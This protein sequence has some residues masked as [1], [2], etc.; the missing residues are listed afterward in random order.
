M[1]SRPT[2]IPSVIQES[3]YSLEDVEGLCS[4]GEWESYSRNPCF[5][6]P[7]E[8]TAESPS[9]FVPEK[10]RWYAVVSTNYPY[11]K[12]QFYPAKH[13]G[14]TAT[15]PHQDLNAE[16]EKHLPWRDGDICVYMPDAALGRK[17]NN[18]DPIGQSKRLAWYAKRAV[19]WVQDASTDKL[20]NTGDHFELPQFNPGNQFQLAYIDS[21]ETHEFWQ[22]SAILY[23]L[24]E[25]CYRGPN[26]IFY[27][28]KFS[29]GEG[30]DLLTLPWGEFKS[31]FSATTTHAV[32]LRLPSPPITPPYQAPQTWKELRE[33]LKAQDVDFE[34]F[35]ISIAA[36]LRP[37]KPQIIILGFPIPE[38][39]GG[40][41][42][43]HHW[44]PILAPRLSS[45]NKPR[46]GF[47]SNPKSLNRAD[48]HTLS[49]NLS[50]EWQDSSNWN[51]SDRTRRGAIPEMAAEQ[52][53][54]IV[55]CG[56]LGSLVATSLARAGATHLA[57]FD[58]DYFEPGNLTRHALDATDVGHGKARS[59]LKQLA[60][61]NPNAQISEGQ[62]IVCKQ[63][64]S[65]LEHCH[66]VVDCSGSDDFLHLLSEHEWESPKRYISL[67][68]GFKAHRLY[69]FTATSNY[70]PKAD[71]DEQV[72]PWLL[73]EREQI[74]NEKLPWE[75]VGCW[76]PVF[77][78]RFDDMSLMAAIAAKQIVRHTKD[79]TAS[80]VLTVYQQML[81][82]DGL[83]N[84]VH[85]VESPDDMS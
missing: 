68:V 27:L 41:T 8:I 78:A 48:L 50:L 77:P 12:I 71:F 65:R 61:I 7:L 36:N 13:G 24:C 56:S 42:V 26:S 58:S 84:G 28:S 59:L 74:Q 31:Q 46:R 22:Q 19:Q 70:F 10:T 43:R 55:G 14:I 79:H 17:G 3:R 1:E 25:L 30:T 45:S 16:T 37:Q 82:K 76:H 75:G 20:Q 83:F 33:A 35:F 63:D 29:D 6:L 40:K 5:C 23:G 67:S 2:E 49:G 81:D 62:A 69:S 66:V 85:V 9:E 38:F 80:S 15:F 73:K 11:G 21:A 72:Y 52:S 4:I 18:L 39:I 57:L 44:Q 64:M 51:L 34:A 60:R 53:F 47:G 32:W 54:A